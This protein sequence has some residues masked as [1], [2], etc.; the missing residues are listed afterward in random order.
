LTTL[1]FLFFLHPPSP[2]LELATRCISASDPP[3]LL[4]FAVFKS[5]CGIRH[6][7][8]WSL[9]GGVGM[10]AATLSGTAS[11]LLYR[12]KDRTLDFA[13]MGGGKEEDKKE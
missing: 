11:A 1:S 4:P 13:G 2:R 6:M 10:T 3:S 7:V 12:A 9:I 5:T 8:V